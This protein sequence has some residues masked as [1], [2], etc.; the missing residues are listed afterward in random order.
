M[1]ATFYMIALYSGF[2]VSVV[3]FLI[4]LSHRNNTSR[5][6]FVVMM[7]LILTWLLIQIIYMLVHEPSL[8]YVLNELKFI[9][10][11]FIPLALRQVVIQMFHIK[12]DSLIAYL[13]A[14]AQLLFLGLIATNPLHLLFRYNIRFEAFGDYTVLLSDYNIGFWV[15]TAIIYLMLTLS[16]I[17]L[18][19]MIIKGSRNQQ[20]Q[21]AVFLVAILFPFFLNAIFVFTLKDIFEDITPIGF[22]ITGIVLLYG[23]FFHKLFGIVIRAKSIIFEYMDDI[24]MITDSSNSIIDFNPQAVSAFPKIEVGQSSKK[25][26][27]T[28][29]K[30]TARSGIYISLIASGESL[31]YHEVETQS[32]VKNNRS[33]GNLIYVRN[34]TEQVLLEEALSAQQ[35]SIALDLKEKSEYINFLMGHARNDV[36]RMDSLLIQ[37][38]VNTPDLKKIADSALA[39]LKDQIVT[40]ESFMHFEKGDVGLKMEPCIISEELSRYF[41]MIQFE[42]QK[43]GL[44]FIVEMDSLPEHLSVDLGK[45]KQILTNLLMN[46]IKFTD[47][48]LIKIYVTANDKELVFIVTDTGQGMSKEGLI[49][50]L[51]P[52]RQAEAQSVVK[53]GTGLGLALVRELVS[54]MGGKLHVESEFGQG[55]QV[56]FQV[57]YHPFEKRVTPEDIGLGYV[58]EVLKELDIGIITDDPLFEVHLSYQL[59]TYPKSITFID[60]QRFLVSRM[61]HDLYIIDQSWL[62]I[63]EADFVERFEF[64]FINQIPMVLAAQYIDEGT[65]VPSGN[66]R[67]LMKPFMAYDL[68]KAILKMV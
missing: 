23:I 33:I 47:E 66:C 60:G 62:E 24:L 55:T 35:Q 41:E 58:M 53:G 5:N 17:E 21:A 42:A 10:V 59:K 27:D 16:F 51:K 12:R 1:V 25:L 45:L 32:I 48:G 18:I 40:V 34:V 15:F 30:E 4:A 39:L 7:G 19:V 8:K 20:E 52:F 46:A 36:F 29:L 26:I 65:Y 31:Q 38:T 22:A 37:G 64:R 9:S 49:E 43:K 56:S 2:A 54:L 28:Y 61:E 63:H 14:T 6:S 44:K 11:A 50:A 67:V 3:V 13:F 57:K 68:Y